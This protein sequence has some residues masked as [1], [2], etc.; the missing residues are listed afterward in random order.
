MDSMQF[1]KIAGAVLLTVLIGFVITE[2]SHILVHPHE[3]EKVA[4]P[5][6]EL[7][8]PS[9]TDTAEAKKAEPTIA[10]LLV[11][12]SAEKG[13]KVF[14]KC[15]SCHTIEEGGPNKVGPNLYGVLH[16]DIG[17]HEGFAY[18]ETLKGMEGDWTFEKLNHFL[19]N[20][21]DYAPGTKM[22]FAGLKKGDDRA[23][24]LLYI[25]QHGDADAPLPKP[26]PAAD[27]GASS[28]GAADSEAA[29]KE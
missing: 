2:V 3:V 27:E 20:P 16:R 25:R 21:R 1:N 23:D 10:E 18:S 17:S 8:E 7:A 14:N 9:S 5:V 28:D 4:Y 29:P 26:E 22:G 24:L 15:K 19:T 13:E 12:A 6:P 11:N